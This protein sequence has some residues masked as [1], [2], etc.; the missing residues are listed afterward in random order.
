MRRP[1]RSTR[2]RCRPR[3]ASRG[4][5]GGSPAQRHAGTDCQYG[6]PW[7]HT[8][9]VGHHRHRG[10]GGGRSFLP[11][12]LDGY[13]SGLVTFIGCIWNLEHGR[14]PI[15][16]AGPAQKRSR[17]VPCSA[18]AARNRSPGPT[19]SVL[20]TRHRAVE[21][22]AGRT[23]RRRDAT[24]G[25]T[26]PG[27]SP[28]QTDGRWRIGLRHPRHPDDQLVGSLEVEGGSVV[29]SGVYQR[30]LREGTRTFHHLLDP[31]TGHPI[32]TDITSLTIASGRSVDGEIWTSRL[33]GRPVPEILQAI[34]AEPAVSAPCSVAGRR[35]GATHSSSPAQF[36]SPP[37]P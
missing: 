13:V 16:A 8:D 22:S 2:A 32:D 36:S 30:K 15:R 12:L 17:R 14:L 10:S 6:A 25:R 31:R 26:I 21:H 11:S 1:A 35:V 5:T 33:S 34:D 28:R 9:R 18:G 27:S 29:T 7:S 3:T 37:G 20:G 24:D 4:G 19:R 23:A